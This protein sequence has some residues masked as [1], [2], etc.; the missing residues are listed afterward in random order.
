MGLIKCPECGKEISDKAEICVNCGFP[1]KNYLKEKGERSDYLQPENKEI[2]TVQ[3]QSFMENNKNTVI[4]ESC[5]AENKADADYCCKCGSPIE[6]G[7]FR[8]NFTRVFEEFGNTDKKNSVISIIAAIFSIFGC[9]C[10]VGL[11]LAIVDLCSG[12][13]EK[14]HKWSIFAILVCIVWTIV[15]IFFGTIGSNESDS[16]AD[17][18][19]E[20]QTETE[21]S[22]V[23]ESMEKKPNKK[24]ED[25]E[26]A[27]SEKS[28]KTEN[29]KEKKSP[30]KHNKTVTSLMKD[31]LDEKVAVKA[32][33]I[34]K[35]KIGFKKI[36]YEKKANGADMYY[37]DAD[38]YDV[39]I[40]ASDKVYRIFIPESDY[41]FYEDGKVK[42]TAKK[43][44]DTTIDQN[45]GSSYYIMAQEIVK[46]SLLNPRGAKFP[47]YVF[48]SDD[49]AMQKDGKLIAV[50]SYVDATNGYGATVRTKW[51]V[52]FVVTDIDSFSYDLKYVKVG[53][54]SY[55]TF[56]KMN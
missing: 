7:G 51:T 50:Q 2:E 40:T 44:E 55:G 33:N 9:M 17:T 30:K 19:I 14:Q 29:S 24:L 42:L 49:V 52:Q 4:C 22:Q 10:Y 12:K 8:N 26:K 5:G 54:D 34:L 36:A 23:V 11:I 46:E 18:Q 53:D 43:L 37:I 20:S 1:I 32:Y 35:K 6:D 28:T 21:A 13:K 38:G 16:V 15:F 41:V 39:A 31:G 25:K 56:E 27:K 3:K 45:E 48:N 47:S